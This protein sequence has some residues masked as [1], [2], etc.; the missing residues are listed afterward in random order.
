MRIYQNYYIL[1]TS[2]Q[3]LPLCRIRTIFPKKNRR[4]SYEHV[5]NVHVLSFQNRSNNSHSLFK[6]GFAIAILAN[7]D[8]T[9]QPGTRN[10][11]L[12]LNLHNCGQILIISNQLYLLRNNN[13]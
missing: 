6:M 9:G 3:V 12:V 5:K 11:Y 10:L 2:F 13:D 7:P 8:L 1:L 4:K